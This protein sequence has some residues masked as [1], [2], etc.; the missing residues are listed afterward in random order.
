MPPLDRELSERI[1]DFAAEL[2]ALIRQQ[3]MAAVEQ[4]MAARDVKGTIRDALA[5]G[6]ARGVALSARVPGAKRSAVELGATQRRLLA[7]VRS[8]PGERVEQIVKAIGIPTKDL[9]LP[10]RKLI[11]DGTIRTTG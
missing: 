8:H 11:A 2:T 5:R 4:R 3:T 1:A 7:R 9:A 6:R 10:I